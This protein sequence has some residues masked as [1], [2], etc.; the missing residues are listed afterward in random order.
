MTRQRSR[1]L[2]FNE[3][4]CSRIGYWIQIFFRAAQRSQIRTTPPW[5]VHPRHSIETPRPSDATLR[6][7]LYGSEMSTV[8]KSNPGINHLGDNRTTP[9]LVPC[10]KCIMIPI[11]RRR[12]RLIESIQEPSF[13]RVWLIGKYSPIERDKVH[14]HCPIFDIGFRR[15]SQQ[16]RRNI[17]IR[18]THIPIMPSF[19]YDH[20]LLWR[21][22]KCF[23][24]HENNHGRARL[25]T[26][27][28]GQGIIQLVLAQTDHI[29][30]LSIK[31][32]LGKTLK[33]GQWYLGELTQSIVLNISIELD[34]MCNVEHATVFLILWCNITDAGNHIFRLISG[35]KHSISQSDAL[36]Q[37]V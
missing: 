26:L 17:G 16:H 12:K 30:G 32:N 3:I 7:T 2:I 22:G 24:F 6:A 21:R 37:K 34:L 14:G 10:I 15:E 5:C 35:E 33:F 18:C 9:N 1:L 19:K 29:S 36:L 8:L 23:A 28:R 25:G 20:T 31:R 11:N 13:A 4:Y 27:T